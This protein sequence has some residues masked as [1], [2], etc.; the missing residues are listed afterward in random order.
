M[1]AIITQCLSDL[2]RLIEGAAKIRDDAARRFSEARTSTDADLVVKDIAR[3]VRA[4]MAG[5]V[6]EGTIPDDEYLIDEALWR[7]RLH[8]YHSTVLKLRS[9][10]VRRGGR[11][12]GT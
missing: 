1:D 8:G 11:D 9:D 5:L 10:L 6:R 12:G 3:N 2:D 7:M 4:E